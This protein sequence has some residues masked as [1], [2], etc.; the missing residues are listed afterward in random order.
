MLRYEQQ[1]VD[2]EYGATRCESDQDDH[3]DGAGKFVPSGRG[4]ITDGI[5]LVF[6][7]KDLDR[8]AV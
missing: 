7:I 5:S 8:L 1:V 2:E 6:G 3:F 4:D